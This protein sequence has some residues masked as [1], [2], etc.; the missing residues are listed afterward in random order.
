MREWKKTWVKKKM[1]ETVAESQN[2]AFR[3]VVVAEWK[4]DMDAE[5]W[6]KG[7]GKK[8]LIAK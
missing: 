3:K 2:F 5:I 7:S 4:N 8:P 6:T 1:K